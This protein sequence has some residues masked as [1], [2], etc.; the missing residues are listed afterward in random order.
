MN[1]ASVTT[2]T[3]SQAVFLDHTFKGFFER[4][5]AFG[6]VNLRAIHHGGILQKWTCGKSA[7]ELEPGSFLYPEMGLNV[8]IKEGLVMH[9]AL[10]QEPELMLRLEFDLLHQMNGLSIGADPRSRSGKAMEAFA[11]EHALETLGVDELENWRL[12]WQPAFNM[13]PCCARAA[14]RRI[15][16]AHEHPLIR[17]FEH[18]Q[19]NDLSLEVRHLSHQ[20]SLRAEVLPERI[21]L[22]GGWIQI[23]DQNEDAILNL[24]L[25]FI[26]ALAIKPERVDGLDQTSM[27]LFDSHGTKL[28]EISAPSSLAQEWKLLCEE[29]G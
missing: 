9:G 14:Q 1:S 27:H 21:S 29:A 15:Q 19:A 18:A 13:C 12:D 10:R 22:Q 16:R 4:L 23:E 6:E 8:A 17:I 3:T 7:L 25:F 20:V 5:G 11:Q 28:I 2:P 24:N 26:H